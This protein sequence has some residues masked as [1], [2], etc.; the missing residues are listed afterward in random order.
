MESPLNRPSGL[1]TPTVIC[2][3]SG[4]ETRRL[5]GFFCAIPLLLEA[6]GR[7]VWWSYLWVALGSA[8]GGVARF[9]C[10]GLIANRIG[11]VFPWGTLVV[12][13]SGSFVIGFFDT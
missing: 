3:G 7:Q 4:C 13:V 2:G 1:M 12:N 10:S 11:E 8:L 5:S 6:R 9:A